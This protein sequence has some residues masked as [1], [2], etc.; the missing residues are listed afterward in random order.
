MR[1]ITSMHAQFKA[2]KRTGTVLCFEL[3]KGGYFSDKEEYGLRVVGKTAQ[4]R[5]SGKNLFDPQTLLDIGYKKQG[6]EYFN[7]HLAYTNPKFWSNDKGETGRFTF[8]YNVKFDADSQGQRF[9][10]KYTDGTISLAYPSNAYNKWG[11]VVFTSL[12]TK[13][14]EGLYSEVGN[15]SSATHLKDIQL[16]FSGAATAYEPYCGEI[17]SPSPGYPQ[18]IQCVKAG[19]KVICGECE[20]TTPRDLYE[21]DIYF[22]MTGKVEKYNNVIASYNGEIISTEYFSTTGGLDNGAKVVYKLYTP[23]IEKYPPQPIFM[24]QGTVDVLQEPES[25]ELEAELSATVLVRR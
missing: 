16:E 18:E 20:I 1:K 5:L 15:I 23:E 4:K 24:P 2:E 6:D 14:V 17:P 11:F 25:I 3:C 12:K 13:T 19:T 9:Y 21:S 22:P 10:F 8:S 7:N